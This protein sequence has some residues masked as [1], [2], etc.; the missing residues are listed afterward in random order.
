MS[1]RDMLSETRLYQR[2]YNRVRY[3][4]GTLYNIFAY[5]CYFKFLLELFFRAFDWKINGPSKFATKVCVSFIRGHKGQNS[6]E[7]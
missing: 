4:Q 5:T 3:I 7:T 1:L 2:Y 6:T